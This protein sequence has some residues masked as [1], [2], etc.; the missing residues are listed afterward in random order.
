MQKIEAI[1]RPEKLDD[2]KNALSDAKP[3]SQELD[4][5]RGHGP[6]ASAPG[7]AFA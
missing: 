7:R 4:G 5:G 6:G 1:I 3:C 2:V